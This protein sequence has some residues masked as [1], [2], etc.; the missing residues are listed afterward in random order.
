MQRM[1]NVSLLSPTEN[2]TMSSVNVRLDSILKIL[3][4][5]SFHIVCL[6]ESLV[7]KKHYLGRNV[8]DICFLPDPEL[9]GGL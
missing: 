1:T 7:I 8:F 2:R 5:L 6:E 9:E 3:L 4:L